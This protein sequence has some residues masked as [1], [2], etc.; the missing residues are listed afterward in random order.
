MR[1]SRRPLPG[2]VRLVLLAVSLPAIPAVAADPAGT[3]A[4][5]D[6]P[7]CRK[8]EST[9]SRIAGR[10]CHTRAEWLE[11]EAARRKQADQFQRNM[12]NP[13]A[14]TGFSTSAYPR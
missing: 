2:L 6:R 5:E 11:I 4:D 9:G 13:S 8:L 12:N 10:E 1:S 7:V 14:D 3:A